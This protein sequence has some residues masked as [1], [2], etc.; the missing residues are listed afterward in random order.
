MF[1]TVA[2]EAMEE[3]GIDIRNHDFLGCL[4]NVQPKNAP[5]VVAPFIFLLTGEVHPKT[6][7]EAKEIVWIPISFLLDPRNVS[8]IIVPIGDQKVPMGCYKY[9]GHVIWG[10]SFRIIREITSKIG[11]VREG[12]ESA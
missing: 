8:S 11:V 12:K 10:M 9:E 4:S 3:V 7:R 1:D 2:R 5:M 6:S